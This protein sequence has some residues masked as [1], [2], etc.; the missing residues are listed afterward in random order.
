MRDNHEKLP[1]IL[2]AFE[3]DG[4]YFGVIQI[5]SEDN[6]VAFEFGIDS[7]GYSALRRVL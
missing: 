3:R 6:L 2:D 5:G 4:N 7:S 1:E